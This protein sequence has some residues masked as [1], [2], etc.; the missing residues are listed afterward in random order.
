MAAA[1]ISLSI[2]RSSIRS[3]DMQATAMAWS[4]SS[5]SSLSLPLRLLRYVGALYRPSPSAHLLHPKPLATAAYYRPQ[6]AAGHG[7]G[8]DVAARTTSVGAGGA[9]RRGCH[10]AA[11]GGDAHP[12][13][14]DACQ[15]RRSPAAASSATR[16]RVCDGARSWWAPPSRF[17]VN[18]QPY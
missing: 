3:R 11:G 17:V 13:R 4:S 2:L 7:G 5:S 6:E 16:S 10:R 18:L 12:C 14:C 9:R 1:S 15:A 8:G